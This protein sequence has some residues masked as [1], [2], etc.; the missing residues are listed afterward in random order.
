MDEFAKIWKIKFIS[1][2]VR[3]EPRKVYIY[4][5]GDHFMSRYNALEHDLVGKFLV[6]LYDSVR[7][8]ILRNLY[9][10]GDYSQ[11]TEGGR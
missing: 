7:T 6:G 4:G 5:E 9:T 3:V 2:D 10:D 1:G 8:F 11:V